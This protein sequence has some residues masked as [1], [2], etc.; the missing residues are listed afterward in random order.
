MGLQN[1]LVIFVAVKNVCPING[2]KL[3]PI[4][5]LEAAVSSLSS[6]KLDTFWLRREQR[7][8]PSS[9]NPPSTTYPSFNYT[10][11]QTKARVTFSWHLIF[12]MKFF[13][14]Y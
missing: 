12:H 14:T 6:H 5:P 1:C 9:P 7:S 11:D 13:L 8:D 10:D 2:I 3:Q 4:Q